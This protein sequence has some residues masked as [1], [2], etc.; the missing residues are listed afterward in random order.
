MIVAALALFFSVGA[1]TVSIYTLGRVSQ[2][3]KA[4]D[5]RHEPVIGF[6]IH[7]SDD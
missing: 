5:A 3:E 2:L 7:R 1:L 6:G 4:L